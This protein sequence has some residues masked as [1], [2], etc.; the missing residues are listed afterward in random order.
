MKTVTFVFITVCAMMFASCPLEDNDA[1]WEQVLEENGYEGGENSSSTLAAPRGVTATA[2]SSSSI[3]ISWNL[4]PGATGYT[5]YRSSSAYGD[6]VFVSYEFF[7][8]SYTDTWLSANTTYYYKVSAYDNNAENGPQSAYV[9]ATT[10]SA[11]S[12]GGEPGAPTGVTATATSSDSIMVSWNE[13]DG[14]DGYNVYRGSSAFG[15][16]V[17]MGDVYST[18]YTDT[19]LSANTTYYYRIDARGIDDAPMSE[20]A[21]A[22]TSSSGSGGGP[23]PTG[24]TA[25]A[26][27]S[28]SITVSWDPISGVVFYNIYRSSSASGTYTYI[29]Q[30]QSSTSYTDTG[31][32]A[33]TTYYYKVTAL[34][35]NIGQGES[36]QSSYAFATTSSSSFRSTIPLT[37]NQWSID[38]TSNSELWYSFSVTSGTSYQIWWNDSYDGDGTKTAD[39]YVSVEY[40]NGT[41]IFDR[42]DSGWSMGWSFT[43]S[44]SGT[45][46]VKVEPLDSGNY[47]IVYS[48]SLY[49]PN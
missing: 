49:R 24:V 1:L 11:D 35:L 18:S 39:I 31:L 23:I 3:T 48:T 40:S 27:S 4:V 9:S 17:W 33:N 5:I 42:I 28:S 2:T 34:N 44:S 36:S 46:Y 7:S 16:Y 43:A 14:A 29:G 45:V 6:Y 26:T 12:G 32:S 38:A 37:M 21:F 20:Y 19:G 15:T 8:N 25:T 47:G 10:L 41:P 13:V 30:G 22:T